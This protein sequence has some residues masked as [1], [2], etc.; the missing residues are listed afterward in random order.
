MILCTH[1][2][3]RTDYAFLMT[4]TH[5]ILTRDGCGGNSG[6]RRRTAQ[7]ACLFTVLHHHT[8]E[9]RQLTLT[10]E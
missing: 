5:Q 7:V 8:L 6:Y 2:T 10:L 3:N 1:P 4:K 9:E